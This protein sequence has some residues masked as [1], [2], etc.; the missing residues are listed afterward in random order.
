LLQLESKMKLVIITQVRENYGAHDWN[1]V[2][3]VPQYWK[4]KGGSEYILEDLEHYLSINDDFFTKKVRMIVESILPNIEQNSDFYQ[5]T[6]INFAIEDDD[7]MSEYEKSQ[8]EYEGF[9]RF[10]EPRIDIDG[11]V[12]AKENTNTLLTVDPLPEN[13]V[14]SEN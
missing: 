11:N 12:L 8:L 7:Y 1:G 3:P 10:Y 4:N 2:G 14:L 5:E 9:I 13:I 6:I